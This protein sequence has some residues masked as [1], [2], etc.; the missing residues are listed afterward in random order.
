MC[1]VFDTKVKLEKDKRKGPELMANDTK[2]LTQIGDTWYFDF[3]IPVKLKRIFKTDRFRH[4]L[5]TADYKHAKYI[6]DRYLMP[7]FAAQFAQEFIESALQVLDIAKIDIDKKTTEF[8]SFVNRRNSDMKAMTLREICD[9]YIKCYEKSRKAD[10]SIAKFQATS[11]SLCSILGGETSAEDV[12][13]KDII[14]LRD[15]LLSLPVGWQKRNNSDKPELCPAEEGERV[16]NPNS[17]KDEIQRIKSIF[18]RAIDD[19]KIIRTDNPAAKVKVDSVKSEQKIPPSGDCVGKLCNMRMTHSKNYDAEAWKY[20][21]LFAR[22]T[23]CRIGELAI[24]KAEDVVEK[25]GIRCLHITARGKAETERGKLKTETSERYVPVS[26]ILSRYLD[27]ILLKHNSGYLFPK[28]GNWLNEKG[29]IRKPAHFFIKDYNR[30]AKKIDPQHSF[31]CWRVYANTQMA[32]AGIDILD[33]EAILG[34]KSDR[35]QR[36]YTAENMQRLKKAVDKII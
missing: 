23:G 4:S 13:D 6:R 12:S 10:S 8:L 19:K 24:L 22:Y 11:N 29:K 17:V 30:Y 1:P 16:M 18:A 34:H 20:L 15:I 2:Y 5:N 27:E 7:L 31:H 33:R 36:V 3:R 35:I 32:D 26:D 25:Q 14:S 28:C 9:Y 21:P